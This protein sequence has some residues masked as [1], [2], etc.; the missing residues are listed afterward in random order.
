MK[1]KIIVPV[2]FSMNALN[3][4]NYARGLAKVYNA[5][6]EV[7]HVYQGSF[8][9]KDPLMV[10][11]GKSQKEVLQER[12]D[13]FVKLY[14]VDE[15]ADEI[16]EISVKTRLIYGYPVN[17]LIHTSKEQGVAMLV[18]GAT[19]EHDAVDRFLGSVSSEVVQRAYCPV[20]IVPKGYKY[21]PYKNILYSSNY[22]SADENMLK[23]I[24]SFNASF[25]AA[26]HFINV[27]NKKDQ[28]FEA[29]ENQIYNQLFEKGDPDFSFHLAS[30]NSN[31]ISK[32]LFQYANENKIDLI[33]MVNKQRG[34]LESMLGTSLTKK[35]ALRSKYP[36]LV[37]HA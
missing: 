27:N 6:I 2:D 5:R 7:V 25:D 34:L 16:R 35:I 21:K 3:A 15:R 36:I 37:Y 23:R 24:L 30:I 13:D 10:Q 33:V 20:L 19:G 17:S 14:P 18:M 4:Y 32:G 9:T 1:K 8:N 22:E 11:S 28:Q 31:S 12:L 26:I 29:V